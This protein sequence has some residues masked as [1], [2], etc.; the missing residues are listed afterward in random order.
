MN[1]RPPLSEPLFQGAL[2][3]SQGWSN[4]ITQVFLCLPWKRGFNVTATIDFG[5]AAAQGQS[6]ATVTIA[7]V[8]SGDAVH[9]TPTADVSGIVFTGVV[10]AADTVTVYAKNY[11]AAGID[12]ASQ[13]FRIIVLQN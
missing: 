11:S 13:V 7:G 4:W 12:P 8:R 9:V 2:T 6:S 5:S 3:L 10:T 1:N